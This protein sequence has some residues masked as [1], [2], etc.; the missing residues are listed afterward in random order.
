MFGWGAFPKEDRETEDWKVADWAIE[1]LKNPPKGK[2]FFLCIGFRRPHVPIFSPQK[3]FDL[4]PDDDTLF[5]PPVRD[6]DLADLPK[7]ASYQHWKLPEPTLAW[8]KAHHQWRP[9][10]RAYLAAV[11]FVDSQVG[12]VVDQLDAAGLSDRTIIVLWSDHGW[13]LGEKGMTGKTTLWERS[14]HVP[15][16][17]AG[18]NI[19]A[20][21]RCE[22][23]VE[24]LDLYPTLVEQCGLP[25]KA[26]LEGHSLARQ[27]KDPT[28]PRPWPAITTHGQN[29]HA[30]RTTRWRYIRYPDGSEELYDRQNDPNEWTNLASNAK[31]A[32]TK[33]E[34]AKWLPTTNIPPIPGSVTRLVEIRA[35]GQVYWQGKPIE[36][37]T[38]NEP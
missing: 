23:A 35:G 37:S 26:G 17:I 19:L 18:P 5:M 25:V 34:L 28:A 20:G 38:P 3:W 27:L 16:I 10:V 11:S 7:F 4:Y 13:H 8:L 24:L 21:G 1:Q 12:R 14:T 31:Y 30:I 6:D 15:L 9:I 33:S 32:S 2:P 29:S 22:Q 36:G